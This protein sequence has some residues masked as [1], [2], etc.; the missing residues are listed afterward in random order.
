MQLHTLFVVCL[1]AWNLVCGA[2]CLYC[3]CCTPLCCPKTKIL[4]N[5]G[6]GTARDCR[7]CLPAEAIT[8]RKFLLPATTLLAVLLLAFGAAQFL[9]VALLCSSFFVF[10]LPLYYVPSSL[11]LVCSSLLSLFFL[12]SPLYFSSLYLAF[13]AW[14]NEFVNFARFLRQFLPNFFGYI[15]GAK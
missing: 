11:S 2:F 12:S 6:S 15:M 1:C 7:A 8:R 14:H 5:A 3:V 4:L 13:C 10:L 9:S